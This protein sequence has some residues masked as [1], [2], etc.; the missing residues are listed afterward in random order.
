LSE[1]G[2]GG[3]SGPQ[4]ASID[5]DW[6]PG[7]LQPDCDSDGLS[8][9]AFAAAVPKTR[10]DEIAKVL[11]HDVRVSIVRWLWQFRLDRADQATRRKRL[12]QASKLA[13]KLAAE[14][15][16]IARMDDP[17]IVA[18]F[19]DFARLRDIPDALIRPLRLSGMRWLN[20]LD[21]YAWRAAALLR[22]NAGAPSFRPFDRLLDGMTNI[23]AEVTGRQL[24]ISER[25]DQQYELFVR[26]ATVELLGA[27]AARLTWKAERT[28]PRSGERFRRR[29]RAAAARYIRRAS[30]VEKAP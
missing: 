22:D 5:F 13:T 11:G 23:F 26:L 16:A 12:S 6:T 25:L 28:F 17:E 4:V 18:A 15:D 19:A 7:L 29:L 20:I 24:I 1:R 9:T 14:A 8:F 30:S 3:P 2:G 21:E 10:L 27:L